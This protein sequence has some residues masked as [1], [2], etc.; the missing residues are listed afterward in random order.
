[1]QASPTPFLQTLHEYLSE[2]FNV[3]R[4][5]TL[6]MILVFCIHVDSLAFKLIFHLI[7][8]ILSSSSVSVMITRSTPYKNSHGVQCRTLT[9]LLVLLYI[10][11]TNRTIHSSMPRFCM[12]HQ[13]TFLG[14]Q[15]NALSRSTKARHR[16][17]FLST[18]FSCNCLR[19]N[20]ASI[21]H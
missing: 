16:F 20:T 1:M 14:T 10:A 17:W 15:S 4:L 2:S 3:W 12:A 19:M 9:L 18:W 21:V 6:T 5:T 7:N 11:C 8:F 13:I